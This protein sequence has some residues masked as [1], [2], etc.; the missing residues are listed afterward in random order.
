MYHFEKKNSKKFSPARPRENVWWLRE[1]VS[2]GPAVA[3]DGRVRE[4]EKCFFL[5]ENWSYLGN[6]ERGPML[7]LITNR[8]SHIG[9]QMT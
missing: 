7:L 4:V 8:K 6:G 2:L 3:L 5:T 9:F 1:N